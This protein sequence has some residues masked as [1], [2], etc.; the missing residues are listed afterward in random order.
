[1]CTVEKVEYLSQMLADNA[2]QLHKLSS[3]GCT[4]IEAYPCGDHYH[5]GHDGLTPE[6]RSKAATC[7]AERPFY[8]V[9]F[10]RRMHRRRKARA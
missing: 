6:A 4:T 2:V 7:K 8:G 5:L 3:P 9:P 10:R 1:M